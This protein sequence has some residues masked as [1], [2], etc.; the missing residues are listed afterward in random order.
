MNLGRWSALLLLPLVLLLERFSY[1]GMR[2]L[3][4]ESLGTSGELDTVTIRSHV[5]FITWVVT[6]TPPLGGLVAIALKPRWTVVAG[7]A[8]T[9]AGYALLAALG[10]QSVGAFSV[11]AVGTGLVRPAIFAAAAL[12]VLDPEESARG[13]VFVAL[14]AALNIGSLG[15]AALGGVLPSSGSVQPFEIFTIG[16]AVLLMLALALA[17]GV[18]AA[19]R[20]G[21]VREPA[22]PPFTGRG[23]I[24]SVLVIALAIPAMAAMTLA[25]GL[26]YEPF[27][28]SGN[29]STWIYY[30]NPVAVLAI[31]VLLLGA[32]G[33]AAYA[34]I[35]I[36]AL[37]IAAGG[38]LVVALG[39]APLVALASQNEIAQAGSYLS[40]VLLACG[41][42]LFYPLVMSRVAA[43][44]HPRSATLMLSIWLV[45]SG[46]LSQLVSAGSQKLT[47]MFGKG[48]TGGFLVAAAFLT[49]LAVPAAILVQKF[50]APKLWPASQ[51][52]S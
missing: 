39:C 10:A 51:P 8:I 1:Y 46:V 41:E 44:P 2:S 48:A 22:D 23:E 47:D 9:I 3:L 42:A 17:V 11:V 14:Y 37:Y 20:F 13:A 6:V 33:A 34:G 43:G 25:E 50:G 12:A 31:A 45:F 30:I 18:A 7:L 36:P 38:M 49:L 21:E 29:Y 4:W 40:I 27:F 19:P 52:E 32:L 35:R 28:Q 24:A 15:G 26:Q 16:S 5:T